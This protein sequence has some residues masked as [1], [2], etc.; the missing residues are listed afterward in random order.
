MI[1]QNENGEF[2]SRA[3]VKRWLSENKLTPHHFR[4]STIQ[5]VPSGYH[6]PLHHEGGV[7]QAK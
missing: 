7:K 1:S 3:D 6:G 2:E 5:L 4:D